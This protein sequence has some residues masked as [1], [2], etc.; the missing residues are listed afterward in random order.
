MD[1]K[2]SQ[3]E[4]RLQP[5]GSVDVVV[6]SVFDL[7]VELDGDTIV[8]AQIVDDMDEL[9][10]SAYFASIRQRGSDP[11]AINEGCRWAEVLAGEISVEVIISDVKNAVKEV[12][13]NCNVSFETVTIDGIDYLTYTIQ[14]VAQ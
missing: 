12:G 1:F 11:L 7:Y 9:Y 3:K 13:T 4:S 8:N 10:Q 6:S 2:V 14:V 5:Q